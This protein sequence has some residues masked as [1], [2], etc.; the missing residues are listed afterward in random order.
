MGTTTSS[1]AAVLKQLY[2]GDIVEQINQEAIALN[3]FEEKTVTWAAGIEAIVPL[4][5]GR[6]TAVGAANELQNLGVAG[7]HAYSRLILNSSYVYGLVS[8]SGPAQAAAKSS[9]GAFED[10]VGLQLTPLVEDV[11][12]YMDVCV[13]SGGPYLGYIW[14]KSATLGTGG[15][16]VQASA[17]TA[18]PQLP[19]PVTP[20]GF[21]VKV[22]RMDTF[23][24]V[25]PNAGRT[26]TGINVDGTGVTFSVAIDT[27]LASNAGLAEGT[28]FLIASLAP[29]LA[30]EPLG[31]N[32]NMF[33]PSWFQL[34]RGIPQTALVNGNF[35]LANPTTASFDDLTGNTFAMLN[36]KIKNA[37][38]KS[39][40]TILWNPMTAVSY[41]SLLVGTSSGIP[42]AN[43]N[44]VKAKASKG[45]MG[46][47]A[48]SWANIP[49]YEC[50]DCPLG[51]IYMI[52]KNHWKLAQLE[53][54][55]FEEQTGSQFVKVAQTD[56]FESLYKAY[57]QTYCERPN[58]SGVI[59]GVQ[60]PV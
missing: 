28:P 26:I 36:A 54:G 23:A 8:F 15:A 14:E 27:S 13:F 49:A 55:H 53:A 52:R 5:T 48:F 38:D 19:F 20:I 51:V 34:Q 9:Q 3:L 10:M 59:L 29:Q 39:P 31:M 6:N 35:Q 2:L 37:S 40:D 44:D 45:D 21:A 41:N 16:T 1:I 4:S 12:H 46:F 33:A 7:S 47:T 18:Y 11:R 17:R 50:H 25:D 43:R 60:L 58:S 32:G 57:Y 42:L 30:S 24:E 22:F 56:A